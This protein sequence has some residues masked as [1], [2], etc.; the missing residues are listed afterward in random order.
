MVNPRVYEKHYVDG[1][2]D[3]WQIQEYMKYTM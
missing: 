3:K 1:T 2:A